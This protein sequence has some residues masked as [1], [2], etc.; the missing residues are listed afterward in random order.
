MTVFLFYMSFLR[1]LKRPPSYHA[2]PSGEM[3]LTM[4]QQKRKAKQSEGSRKFSVLISCTSPVFAV[5]TPQEMVGILDSIM[6]QHERFKQSSEIIN[7]EEILTR[8]RGNLLHSFHPLCMFV[9]DTL[10]I[11]AD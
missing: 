3:Q 2:G 8:V 9:S 11:T 1:N 7:N 4:T 6:F 10:N 5:S